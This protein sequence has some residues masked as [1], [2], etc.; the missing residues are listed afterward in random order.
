MSISQ[1]YSQFLVSLQSSKFAGLWPAQAHV[2]QE[3]SSEYKDKADLAIELPTGAGKTL[4]ALLIAEA[5]RREERKVAVLSANKTLARQME[6]ESRELGIPAVLMEGTGPSI[7]A[8]DRRSYHRSQK[9]ALMNYWVY[10]NQNPVVDSADLLIMD[11]AH[12]AE[13]CFHSL[14]SVE[15]DCYDHAPLF[16]DLVTE[17]INRYPEYRILHDAI[18]ENVLSSTPPELL[19]FIDQWHISTRIREIVDASPLLESNVDLRFRWRRL[20]NMLC[21]ANIYI[22]A[23]TIWIRPYVY[24]LINN[25]QYLNTTQRLYMSATIGE[26]SDLS[27]RLGIRQVD[28]IPVPDEFA[29]KTNGRRLIVMNRIEDQDIP[30]R[31]ERVILA[32]LSKCPKSVW[33]CTSGPEAE[34]YKQIVAQWLNQNG[35]VGHST[36]KL[37]SLGNEIEQF[38]EAEKGHLFVGGRFDGM[39]FE[40]D[41]CRLVVLTTLPRAINVQ[42]EFLCGYLRDAG[43]M[44]RRLN[45]RIVQAL[46]RCNRGPD[47]YAVYVL[48]DRRFATHFGRDSNRQ[49]LPRNIM[50]Q[51]DMAEDMAEEDIERV[52][53]DVIKFLDGN[54]TQFDSH[55]NEAIEGLPDAMVETTSGDF[56]SDEVL[57]WTAM[58]QSQNYNIAAERFEKCWDSARENNLIEMGAY[59]GW[60][61]AKARYLQSVQG[62]S[63][64][65]DEA[66]RILENA[67]NRG[68]QSAWFNRMRTSLNRERAIPE[69]PIVS[70]RDEY[71]FAIIQGFDELLERVGQRGTR[72][73]NWCNQLSEKLSSNQHNM[74]CLGVEE[75]GSLLGYTST[76]PRHQAATDCRW[77]G[78]FGSTKEVFV[79]EAKIEDEE[80]ASIVSSDIG[81]AHNQIERAK[82][83]YESL[84]YTVMGIIAT[85]IAVI[86]PEAES[87]MG[88]IRI[89]PKDA[90]I[91]LWDVVKQLLTEYRNVWSL[92]DVTMR[93][94][95]SN[96]IRGKFPNH[97]WLSRALA[98][99]EHIITTEVLLIE[100]SQS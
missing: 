77:K 26:P 18:D 73:Q 45:Q 10:F 63:F 82:A 46:G 76:R 58:F 62:Q 42:E 74:F 35:L 54:F 95:A 12:L 96:A 64:E 89:I 79:I 66:L 16:K 23:R 27:R 70:E 36:W 4:I 43:F 6:S 97:G 50:A 91:Q 94:I 39:D 83:E 68:G 80:P 49:G 88:T 15:I 3:Y 2:L 78:T 29:E 61:W 13:H 5:W 14:W 25:D 30:L 24:P 22:S 69:G 38:K 67:I 47:D 9:V 17:L 57:A 7:S 85:H 87:S 98:R 19:S 93:S 37:T 1:D 72:F 53:T 92:D 34:K 75:L 59:L 65:K 44:K 32:A 99:D 55:F 71:A 31:L 41:E 84:G 51:I 28:K 21:E 48:T 40:G 90:L 33:L 52:E 60:C 56:S 81:Q 11:D 100:W 86:I 20:R 8:R